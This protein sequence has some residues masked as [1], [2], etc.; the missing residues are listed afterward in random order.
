MSGGYFNYDQYR[1]QYIADMIEQ[2]ILN[3][4]SDKLD[5]YDYPI[6]RHYSKE[7]MVEFEV[8]LDYLRKAIIYAQRI[9]W[10]V[11]GDDGEETFHERLK[12]DLEELPGW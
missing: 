10:L 12:N 9:D 5:P 4:D 3:N 7:T 8:G 6:G 11:S 1:I 2:L